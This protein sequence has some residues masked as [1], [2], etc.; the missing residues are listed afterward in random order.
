MKLIFKIV[1]AA[2]LSTGISGC[3]NALYLSQAI[4]GHCRLMCSRVPI[5]KILNK[6]QLDSAAQD[7]LRQVLELREFASKELGLPKNKSYTVYS[8]LKGENLG[9]NVYC[10]PRFSVEPKQWRFPIAGRVVYRGY[11]SKKAAL[12]FARKM[13]EEGY[14]LYVSPIGAYSTLGWFNDPV[15]SSHLR[16][17][18]IQIAGL[19]IHELAH[20]EYY[21]P[22]DS[23]F[24]ESFAVS[25]ERAGIL[26]WLKSTGSDGQIDKA[27]KMWERQDTVRVKLLDVRSRLNEIYTSNLDTATMAQKKDSLLMDLKKDLPWLNRVGADDK[28]AAINNAY[29]VPISTYYSL[30]PV[31][32]GMLDS[33]GG[34]FTQFYQKVKEIGK[35]PAKERQRKIESLRK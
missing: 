30:V 29:F 16:L 27:L 7:K 2:I 4:I 5:K 10:A 12:K 34:N 25:V 35:L 24:S 1:L 11:F 28:Y 26:R 31:F 21:L 23:Q 13:E 15:L 8:E 20:Q 32:Q 9:W 19:I 18:S 6:N 33:L 22:G 14:D 3:S 17:D